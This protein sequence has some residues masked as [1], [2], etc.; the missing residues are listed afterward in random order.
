MFSSAFVY[1]TIF[2]WQN[3]SE[4]Y[5]FSWKFWKGYEQSIIVG[6]VDIQIHNLLLFCCE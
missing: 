5:I 3:F 4:T 6:A 2:W 1:L